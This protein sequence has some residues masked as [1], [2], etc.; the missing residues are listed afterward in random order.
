MGVDKRAVFAG[1]LVV[2]AAVLMQDMRSL[3]AREEF[4]RTG[5][6]GE[7]KL[8]GIRLD[9]DAKDDGKQ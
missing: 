4:K 8:F 1:V 5:L 2:W 9:G 3:K 6:G 7:V